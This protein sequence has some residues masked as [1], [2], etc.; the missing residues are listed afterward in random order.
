MYL[1]DEHLKELDSLGAIIAPDTTTNVKEISLRV[2]DAEIITAKFVN[3]TR[4]IINAAPKLKYIISAA[5]GYDSIDIEHARLKGIKVINCPTHHAAAVAEHTLALLFASVRHTKAANNSILLGGWD[6]PLLE[7][8][9]IGGKQIGIIGNGNI[10]S[11]VGSLLTG[12]GANISYV[13]SSSTPA[14]IDQ[15]VTQSDIIIICAQLNKTTEH[16]ID[17]R[18]LSK[19]KSTA[20]LINVS[21]GAI[22]DQEALIAALKGN[23]IRGA[24][25]DVFEDELSDGPA[26]PAIKELAQ[27]TNVVA[28]P[29][30]GYHT[31]E[32]LVRL[33]EE[34]LVNIRAVLDGRPINVVNQ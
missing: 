2:Q 8:T 20:Y 11:K 13:N 33:S 9:E 7:G 21:R 10:G 28:T 4:D 5:A 3:I 24:G 16:L 15:L 27:M 6:S 22:V 19:M 12:M 29:H 30:I 18:R 34:L 17:K 26:T 23:I 25:L 32:A 14:E 1:T 31:H